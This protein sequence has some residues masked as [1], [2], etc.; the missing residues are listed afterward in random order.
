MTSGPPGQCILSCCILLNRRSYYSSIR[1]SVYSGHYIVFYFRVIVI[2]L[3]CFLLI[4]SSKLILIGIIFSIRLSH[5]N[6][7]KIF[8][9]RITC[10]N[11]M[12]HPLLHSQEFPLLLQDVVL[13]C[14]NQESD[15]RILLNLPIYVSRYLGIATSSLNPASLNSIRDSLIIQIAQSFSCN[16][17]IIFLNWNSILLLLLSTN[18]LSICVIARQK[19]V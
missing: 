15:L 16:F 1:V 7:C 5:I 11:D 4:L 8:I 6:N 9:I 13:H 2:I 14:R 3:S 17:L 12:L 18:E 19:I 10:I